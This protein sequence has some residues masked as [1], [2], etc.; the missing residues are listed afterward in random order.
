[1]RTF[2]SARGI[3]EGMLHLR[4]T[5]VTLAIAAGVAAPADAFM[6]TAVLAQPYSPVAI[7]AC[8]A[9]IRTSGSG[10]NGIT[11]Y[12]ADFGA[13]FTN[14]S[15]LAA[16]AVRLRFDLFDASGGHLTTFFG[17]DD[18]QPIAAGAQ[19]V[20]LQRDTGAEK[21]MQQSGATVGGA[22]YIPAWEWLNTTNTAHTAVCSVDSVRFGNGSRW[23]ATR[24]TAAGFSA[25]LAAASA[26]DGEFFKYEPQ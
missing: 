16:S 13:N 12:Y 14:H 15:T 8:A 23:Q 6:P 10:A 5:L 22:L 11:N 1:M 26:Q 20:D 4:I 17:S 21:S 18:S 19:R 25:A 9:G 24:P 7:D 3:G 2:T